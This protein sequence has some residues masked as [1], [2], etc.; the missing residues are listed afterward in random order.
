MAQT[1]ITQSPTFCPA[2]WTS[3][4]IRRYPETIRQQAIAEI[5]RVVEKYS[6]KHNLAIDT[7]QRYRMTLVDNSYLPKQQY[8][9]QTKKFHLGREKS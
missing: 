3:L 9:L 1:P 7:L 2:P 6:H 8:Q 4:N 5:D